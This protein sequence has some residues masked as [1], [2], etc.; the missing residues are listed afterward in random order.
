VPP[1]LDAGRLLDA[2][3]F[4]PIRLVLDWAL[5]RAR[6][7]RQEILFVQ[8]H[9]MPGGSDHAEAACL[10]ADDVRGARIQVPL[11]RGPDAVMEALAMLRQRAARPIAVF[12][13]GALVDLLR[14]RSLPAGV[15]FFPY[16][17]RAVLPPAAPAVSRA[18]RPAVPPHLRH[19]E[20]ESIHVLREAVAES[21]NPVMLYSAGKDSSVMLHLARK[22]FHPSPPPFPLLHIDTRWKFREMYLFR[23]RAARDCGMQLLVHVNP[24]AIARDINPFDHGSALHTDITK[25]EGLKQALDAHRFDMVFGGARRDEER[26]RAK[27]RIFSFRTATH[28]WDPKNQRPEVWSLYNARRNRDESIRAFPLSNW[29]ELD[30]WHYIHQEGIEVAPLYFARERAV[31]EQDG[32]LVVVDDDRYRLRPGSKIVERRV[33]FRTLGCYPLTG[34]VPSDAT[35]LPEVILELVQAR[36]SERQGRAIDTDATAAMERRKQAG[37]F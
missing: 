24:D 25:T 11:G 17:Y 29:T 3:G 13:H 36:H 2:E 21:S 12:A 16:A 15:H 18:L 27:E 14:D 10:L 8:V 1:A 37:Y 31:V 34:A 4:P 26:A 6:R 23:D 9:P 30:I 32:L 5:A 28:A 33:R 22:A 19:L 20:A 7:R 35:T